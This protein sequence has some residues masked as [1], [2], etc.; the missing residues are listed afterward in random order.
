MNI[1][2]NK[3]GFTVIEALVVAG[4][5][6]VIVVMAGSL[7]SKFIVRRSVDDL[8]HR[9]TSTFNLVRLQAS[10]NGVEYQAILDYDEDENKLTIQTKR[11]DSNRFSDFDSISPIS[12]QSISVMTDYEIIL[13]SADTVEFN[14]NQTVGGA[15][16]IEIRPKS[17]E[18]YVTK[19]GRIV[20]NPFGRIRTV[21]GRWNF[22]T[23]QCDAIVDEQA[24][25]S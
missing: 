5:I 11:G 23:N 4:V 19:C 17:A 13:S 20:I 1:F 12:T 15:G 18:S 24:Q 22:T 6:A 3:K 7:S 16:S 10:R 25:P 2:K 21:I 14:P 8:A 9:I